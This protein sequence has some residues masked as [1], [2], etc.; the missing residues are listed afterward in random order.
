[1]APVEISVTGSSS[2]YRHPERAILSLHASSKGPS[3][4]TVSNEATSTSN[5]LRQML[6]E[7]AP[8]TESNEPTPSAAVTVFSV[9]GLRSWSQIPRDKDNDPKAP[10]YYAQVSIEAT[11]R[12]F[13]KLGEVAGKLLGQPNV[14]ISGVDWRLTDG[15]KNSLG[16]QSRK[17][18]MLNAIE[19]ARDYSEVI[20]REV[21]AV[22]IDDG[23][24]GRNRGVARMA[25]AGSGPGP[26]VLDLTPQDI[27]LSHEVA[28][29]FRGE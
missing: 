20:G 5:Y 17:L 11:F 16:S 13:A 24:S 21:F 2:I 8:K 25:L 19:I 18:A 14:E 6:Q 15:T 29:K 4:T 22:D 3:Q 1:M 10:V 23:F 28:V 7:L 27:E 12:D 26:Q 9:G